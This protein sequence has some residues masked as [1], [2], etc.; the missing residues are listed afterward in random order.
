MAC[1]Y[2]AAANSWWPYLMCKSSSSARRSA[3][4]YIHQFTCIAGG[5]AHTDITEHQRAATRV[6]NS[7]T[8][9]PYANYFHAS[10]HLP[11]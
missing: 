10:Q 1:S 2:S 9:S 4:C 6:V 3:A 8:A 7:E 11:V 5:R